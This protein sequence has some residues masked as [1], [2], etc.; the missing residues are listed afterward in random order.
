MTVVEDLRVAC[1]VCSVSADDVEHRG[2][3]L[4]SAEPVAGHSEDKQEPQEHRGLEADHGRGGADGQ[5]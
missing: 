5:D 3:D 4:R 1:P 2:S